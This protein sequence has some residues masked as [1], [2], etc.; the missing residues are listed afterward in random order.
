MQYTQLILLVIFFCCV[1]EEEQHTHC[2]PRTISPAERGNSTI[3]NSV[4]TFTAP[5][6]KHKCSSSPELKHVSEGNA[7]N[8]STQSFCN[9]HPASMEAFSTC[10]CSHRT[11]EHPK[12]EGPHNVTDSW[13]PRGTL[14]G[15]TQLLAEQQLT[16]SAEDHSQ[17]LYPL[18]A[19]KSAQQSSH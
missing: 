3:F 16:S 5:Q 17:H 14:H 7:Y 13:L 12:L 11:I 9:Q 6:T 4:I 8:S 18:R 1:T 2:Q 15:I 10:V 19:I